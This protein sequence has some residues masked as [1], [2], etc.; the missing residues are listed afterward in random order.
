MSKN[1]ALEKS[2]GNP[3][4]GYGYEALSRLVYA[5]IGGR[6]AMREAALDLIGLR[7]G[8]RVL[9]L[10]CGTGGLTR[11]LLARGAEVTAV[12]WSEPMLRVA[13]KAAPGAHFVRSEITAYAPDSAFDLVLLAF[14][15][16]EL[17]ADDRKVALGIA[18]RSLSPGGRV[19]V[20][21]HAEPSAGLIPKS[22]FRFVHAFEPPSI[23]EWAK[24]TFEPELVRAGLH[25]FRSAS[26]A[27]GTARAVIAEGRD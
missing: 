18:R 20:V 11:K 21:D 3:L 4:I 17:P 8:E 5:P 10:G 23:A 6:D 13:R 1:E 24:S 7:P 2:Y 25:P 26:L 22:M 19:A 16:H 12:D 9:E 27:R 15:L 14:V